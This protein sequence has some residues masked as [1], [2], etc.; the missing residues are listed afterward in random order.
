MA[1]APSAGNWSPAG[2]SSGMNGMQIPPDPNT[3]SRA[4]TPTATGSPSRTSTANRGSTQRAANSVTPL[5]ASRGENWGLP[6]QGSLVTGF[7]RYISV[8]CMADQLVILPEHG[9]FRPPVVVAAPGEL[10]TSVDPFVSAIWKRMNSWGIAAEN[11][12]WKPV[13]RV[14]V[15]PGADSR[16]EE[17]RTL[18][19]R[20]GLVVERR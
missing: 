11:G 7:T 16:F 8:Q 19:D 10:S 3:D 18:L 14:A 15:G 6:N 20:S 2:L 5:A 13:L 9:D 12:Y 1:G 17:L 4:A